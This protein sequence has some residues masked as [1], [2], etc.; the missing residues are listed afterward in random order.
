MSEKG[1]HSQPVELPDFSFGIGA[2][3]ETHSHSSSAEMP[4][5]KSGTP[6]LLGMRG[7]LHCLYPKMPQ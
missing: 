6:E 1:T 5:C 3:K 7:N 4:K 2:E